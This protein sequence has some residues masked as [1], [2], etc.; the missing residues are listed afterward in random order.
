MDKDVKESQ[1]AIGSRG[2]DEEDLEDVDG[3]GKGQT[4]VKREGG[5]ESGG[6][7][8]DALS[9]QL[10][11]LYQLEDKLGKKAIW[12]WLE[13]RDDGDTD[14]MQAAR[15]SLEEDGGPRQAAQGEAR[16]RWHQPD[17]V[18]ESDGGSR[19]T[20]R[21]NTVEGSKHS[22]IPGTGDRVRMR[23]ADVEHLRLKEGVGEREANCSNHH[24]KPN[25]MGRLTLFRSRAIY[26]YWIDLIVVVVVTLLTAHLGYVVVVVG[27]G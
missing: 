26:I 27:I 18:A 20:G 9:K 13:A 22:R 5:H 19:K 23:P 6:A 25:L 10:E 7:A 15:E 3:P 16:G 12:E 17:S 24:Y 11:A 1:A 8:E 4:R 14:K 21:T 2:K